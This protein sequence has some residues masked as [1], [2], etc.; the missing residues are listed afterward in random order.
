MSNTVIDTLPILKLS[1]CNHRFWQIIILTYQLDWSYEHLNA[2][3][4]DATRVFD[5]EISNDMISTVKE[6]IYWPDNMYISLLLKT[7]KADIEQVVL[8]L[9]NISTKLEDVKDMFP[10]YS[11]RQ[12]REKIQELGNIDSVSEILNSYDEGLEQIKAMGFEMSDELIRDLIFENE[13]DLQGVVADISRANSLNTNLEKLQELIGIDLYSEQ[14]LYG[15]LHDAENDLDEATVMLNHYEGAAMQILSMGLTQNEMM[16]R[17]LVV[18]HDGDVNT[19]VD[20]LIT[21][22]TN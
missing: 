15:I 9:Q 2:V 4:F 6:L 3:Y 21:D 7:Y 20:Y 16:V 14:T 13:G 18:E 22:T 1:C 11:D 12:L 8:A 5:M 10:Y 17:S 19:V